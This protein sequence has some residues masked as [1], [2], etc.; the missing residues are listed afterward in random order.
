MTMYDSRT[1]L[2]RQVVE[3]VRKYFPGRVF[4]TIVPRNV[5]LSEAPSF[6][7]PINLYAPNSPGAVAYKVLAAELVKGDMAAKSAA[8][9]VAA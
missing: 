8:Q 6:G 5:R 2:S 3:E 4:R 1:N 7:Q 9:G